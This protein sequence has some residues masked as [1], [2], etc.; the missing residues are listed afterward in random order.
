MRHD[1]TYMLTEHF[2]WKEVVH[3]DTAIAHGIDNTPPDILEL[4]LEHTADCMERVRAALNNNPIDVSSW[5]RS[6]QVNPLVGSNNLTSQ[7]PRGEAVDFTCSTFG[8]PFAICKQLIAL[9]ELIRFDQLI[10]EHSWVHISF[11]LSGTKPRNQVLSLLETGGYAQGLTDKK[12][13][14]L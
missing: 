4:V 7:H 1:L 13:V 6:L 12:G 9:H 11:T 5:Y 14:R 2:S 3:S 10:L 8:T